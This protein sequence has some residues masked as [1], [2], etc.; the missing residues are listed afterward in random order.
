MIRTVM[1]WWTRRRAATAGTIVAALAG[2]AISYDALAAAARDVGVTW[3]LSWL[4]PLSVDGMI[5]VATVAALEVRDLVARAEVWALLAIAIAVSM[6]GNAAHARPGGPELPVV[7]VPVR[8]LWS[9]V[10]AC[11]YAAALHLLVLIHRA[12]APA[13]G[14]VIGSRER[15]PAGATPTQPRP[16]RRAQMPTRERVRVL[17]ARAAETGTGVT[18][19]EIARA[20]GVHPG[21]ARRLLQEVRDGA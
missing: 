18:G 15:A 16:R 2:A 9:A 19:V 13:R 3:Q 4:F 11:A 8:A 1:C 20:V 10:P 7:P 6:A 17:A 12:Q 5:A 14:R 21:H